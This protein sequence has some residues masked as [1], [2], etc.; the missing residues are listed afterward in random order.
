V[1]LPGTAAGYIPFR[2]L[3]ATNRLGTVEVS[4]GS[5]A[6]ALVTLVGVA[7]L[8]RCVWDFFAAG[9]GTLAPVDP[10]RH[11]VVQGLYRVTRN[12]MYNGVLAALLGEA[13]LFRSVALVE[14]ALLV[15]ALFHLFVVLYEE[16]ALEARFGDA[17]RAYRA[18]VPRWGFAIRPFDPRV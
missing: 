10:P 2:I 5:A 4:V 8:L 3:R 6:A 18:A 7:V 13:W 15:F 12:P 17:Y 11:L 9:R 14:Y 16:P 1:L